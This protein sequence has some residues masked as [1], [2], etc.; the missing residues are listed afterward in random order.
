MFKLEQLDA[1]LICTPPAFHNEIAKTAL[2]FGIHVFSEKPFT[3]DRKQASHLAQKFTESGLVNQVGYVNR[4]NNI[5]TTAK[6]YL[7]DG[8]IGNILSFKSEMYSRTIIRADEGKSWRDS[9]KS[10]GGAAFEIAS[11]AI[12]LIIYLIGKPDKISGSNLIKVY[13]KNV[14]DIV[15]STFLYKKGY[16]GTLQV[17][18]SDESYRK[19]INKIEVFGSAGKILADQHSMKIYLKEANLERQLEEGWNVKY[20]TDVFKP[21]QFYV[22]GNEF[23]SQLYHFID[24][25]VDSK[26]DCNCSF[27]DAA[28][29]LD[30]IEQIFEDYKT[31]NKF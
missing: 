5:F 20:I 9:H 14:E 15:M 19:P 3:L 16:S 22:R 26:K 24:C 10:G 25:I 29:T 1:V 30:V 8:L 11:H 4:F 17:N 7:E 23:T 21:V 2:S 13:S 28:D 31:T 18:W 12:D 6:K 27:K